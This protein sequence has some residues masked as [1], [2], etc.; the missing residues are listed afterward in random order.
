MR[1]KEADYAEKVMCSRF[2]NL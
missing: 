2:G 1:T